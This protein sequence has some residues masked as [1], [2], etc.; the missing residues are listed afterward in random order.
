MPTKD[1]LQSITATSVVITFAVVTQ[2]VPAE[3]VSPIKILLVTDAAMMAT[4]KLAV[5]EI[6]AQ[7]PLSPPR[8]RF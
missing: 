8:P 7:N 4:A 6:S 2:Y 5:H 3:T 1:M